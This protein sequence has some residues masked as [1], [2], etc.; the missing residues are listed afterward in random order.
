MSIIGLVVVLIII[1]AILYV[2]NVALPIDAKIK[3]IIN[4]VV[5][6]AVCLWL[7]DQFVDLGTIGVARTRH[8]C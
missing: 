3:T 5:V 7:L 4:V 1:G 2:I 8:K 6:I